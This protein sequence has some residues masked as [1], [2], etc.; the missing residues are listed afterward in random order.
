MVKFE[1]MSRLSLITQF[2]LGVGDILVIDDSN[3]VK[4]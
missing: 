4:F 1:T 2:E 3:S